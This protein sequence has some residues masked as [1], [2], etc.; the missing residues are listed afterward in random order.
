VNGAIAGDTIA[1]TIRT[2]VPNR[3]VA[4]SGTRLMPS[5]VTPDGHRTARYDDGYSGAW[6]LDLDA[7]VA[8]LK[9]P[10]PRLKA[11]RVPIRPFLGGIGVAPG[12]SQAIDTRSLGPWGGNL[13]YREI[14]P[15][16]TVYLPVN[17]DGALLFLG[18]GHAAQGDGEL[19]GDALEVSMN[20][21]FSVRLL[22]GRRTGL[23]AENATSLMAS[24]VAGSLDEALR[25]AT[26]EMS[27]WLQA[28]YRLSASEAAIILG[29]A[30]RYDIAEVVDPQVHVVARIEKAVLPP[31]APD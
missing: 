26:T 11:Y 1:V 29:T 6:V 9:G 20:V 19:T 23:R 2:L 14:G 5:T 31:V 16:T 28:D 21:E 13:D 22:A 10:S 4:N 8:T 27:G 25:I 12:P 17:V 18:D 24:G 3:L 30:M 7:G 15:G